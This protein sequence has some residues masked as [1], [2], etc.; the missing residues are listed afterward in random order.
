MCLV[1]TSPKDE[2]FQ[3]V[4]VTKRIQPKFANVYCI[5]DIQETEDILSHKKQSLPLDRKYKDVVHKPF[6]RFA[7][8]LIERRCMC[9]RRSFLFYGKSS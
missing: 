8:Q 9:E 5:E 3:Y 1:Q 6:E 4:L 7:I 2:S